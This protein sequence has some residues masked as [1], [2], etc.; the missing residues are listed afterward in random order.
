MTGRLVHNSISDDITLTV[1]SAVSGYPATN[2]QN[3]QPSLK[4]RSTTDAAQTISGNF[5]DDEMV[6][7]VVLYNH[8]ISAAGSIAVTL[9]TNSGF[10]TD[11]FTSTVD[12]LDP[13]LGYGTQKYGFDGYGGYSETGWQQRFT[14]IWFTAIAR[15]YWKVVVTDTTNSDEYI[16]IGRLMVGDYTPI[17]YRYGAELGWR[18]QTEVIRTR[19]G[20]LRSD[21]RDPYR[22]TSVESTVLTDTEAA[23]IL[24]IFRAAGHRSDVLWSGFPEN[25]DEYLERRHT[26]LGRLTDYSSNIKEDVGNALTFTIEEGL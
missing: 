4:W 17:T 24:E 1:T 25:S 5:S 3:K 22:Y 14:I 6:G 10:T 18:E 7:C 9:A 13:T 23:D 15:K 26:M 8:N 20:A 16:Q 19:G 12:A 2:M 11:V 21:S